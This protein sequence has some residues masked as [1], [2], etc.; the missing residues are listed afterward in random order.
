[1]YGYQ[2]VNEIST[3]SSDLVTSQEGTIYPVLYKLEGRSFIS[4]KRVQTGKR[5]VRIYYHLEPA[6]EAYLEKLVAEFKTVT[7]GV[8]QIIG[9]QVL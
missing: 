6:G 3:A 7:K 8:L 2:I 9:D 5:M 1:M 4:G